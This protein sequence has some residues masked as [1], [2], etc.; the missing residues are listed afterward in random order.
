MKGGADKSIDRSADSGSL[1]IAIDFRYVALDHVIV[2][3]LGA[4]LLVT[5]YA[6]LGS[7]AVERWHN[8]Q[9]AREDARTVWLAHQAGMPLP[10]IPLHDDSNCSFHAQL[11]VSG[12]AVAWISPLICLGLFIAFL[13]LPGHRFALQRVKVAISCRGPPEWCALREPSQAADE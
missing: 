2:Q 9:H 6:A 7:G 5:C 13:T 1:A 4:I 3:R 12:L 11:H 8:A 10:V